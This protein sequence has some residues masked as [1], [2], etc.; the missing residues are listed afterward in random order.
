MG[1]PEQRLEYLPQIA[2]GDQW[3]AMAVTEPDAGHDF[4][5][6]TTRIEEDGDMVT[7]SG[8]K[9]FI[10]GA[11]VAD[12]LLLIGRFG[13]GLGA[14]AI[15]ADLPGIKRTAQDM[16]GREGLQQWAL[17]VEV[18]VP[19]SALIGEGPLDLGRLQAGLLVE[20]LAFLAVGIGIA[21]YAL[22]QAVDRARERIVFGDK[23]I[24]VYQAISHPLAQAHAL[25]EGARL[26]LQRTAERAQS[27]HPLGETVSDVMVSSL[28]VAQA[29]G[30]TTDRALQTHGGIGWIRER[31]LLDAYLDARALRSSPVAEELVRSIIAER[32]LGLP[33]DR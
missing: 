31:N 26:H 11:D 33:R 24:G 13:Q 25:T 29:A 14:V 19:R 2:T 5:S 10:S 18:R 12:M 3:W 8:A 20:R 17:D 28:L 1:T 23:P 7:V 16:G 27:G 21:D 22:S 15:P 32:T 30:D 6:V 9:C 4:R